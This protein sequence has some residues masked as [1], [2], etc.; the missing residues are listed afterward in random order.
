VKIL[1]TGL[2]DTA[3]IKIPASYMPAFPNPS[4]GHSGQD[5]A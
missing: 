2:F 4:H 1:Q 5:N 3:L